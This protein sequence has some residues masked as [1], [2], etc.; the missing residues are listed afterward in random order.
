MTLVLITKRRLSRDNGWTPRH[1][2]GYGR[3]LAVNRVVDRGEG[4][5][6]DRGSRGSTEPG[7]LA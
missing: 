5:N 2:E 6:E 7:W 3:L 1:E 4:P